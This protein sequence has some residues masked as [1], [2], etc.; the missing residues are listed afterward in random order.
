M[1]RL[2]VCL[3]S[4]LCLQ[5]TLA[6]DHN[7]TQ[8]DVLLHDIV[9]P[10]GHQSAVDYTTLKSN[11]DPLEDY[12]KTI[13]A[14]SDAE[15]QAWPP[16]K[17]QTFLINA[18]NALTL[19]LIVS[20]YPEISSIR[21]LG[22]LILSTPWKKKFFI[23]FGQQRHL[24]Y[25]E[26]DLLR[27][28]FNDPRIHFALVCASKSCPPLQPTAYIAPQLDTQLDKATRIFLTDPERNRY[29]TKNNRLELSSLFKWYRGDFVDA[30]GSVEAFV[31]PYITEDPEIRNILINRAT[32][33]HYLD[34]DW[35][36]NDSKSQ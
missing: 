1:L 31:A 35:S 22:G 7:H 15:Y 2:L 18:Y 12:I 26:H 17:Q 36:L 27:K 32:S 28:E 13:A 34:Y 20:H 4:S 21:D 5:S 24:D 9:I 33:I 10:N 11:P 6:F 23:L 29:N 25:I 8:Y 14:V 30:A 19:K 3:I 16:Q